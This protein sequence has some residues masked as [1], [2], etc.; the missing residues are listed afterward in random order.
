MVDAWRLIY[1]NE[2]VNPGLTWTTTTSPTDPN[3]HH[4]RIDFIFVDHRDTTV[5][6]IERVGDEQDSELN[7]DSWPSD[8]RAVV[9]TL[10]LDDARVLPE[11]S[12]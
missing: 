10:S 9:A 7:L 8:H 12:R 1:A 11:I 3:D 4:D 5:A 2:V 6:K